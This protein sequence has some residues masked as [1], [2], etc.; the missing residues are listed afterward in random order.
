M[1]I[2]ILYSTLTGNT[3]DVASAIFKQLSKK[4]KHHTFKIRNVRDLA[5]H[6]LKNFNAAIVGSSTWDESGSTDTKL[7]LERLQTTKPNLSHLVVALFGL[8]DSQY[9]EFL[10]SLPLLQTGLQACQAQLY[11]NELAIDGFPTPEKTAEALQWAGTFVDS[12]PST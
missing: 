8:G 12:L 11:S 5:L 10:A 4:Y 3:Q 9:K 7:F 6:E 1:N 2:L